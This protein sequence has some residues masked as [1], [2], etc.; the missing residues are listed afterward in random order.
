MSKRYEIGPN[1]SKKATTYTATAPD[2]THLVKKSFN[3][4][5]DTARMY[6]YYFNGKWTASGITL[7]E[8][9]GQDW[10]NQIYLVATKVDKDQN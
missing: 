8:G 1:N 10:G 6:M 9:N 5:T 3:V 4:H 7:I 2:G